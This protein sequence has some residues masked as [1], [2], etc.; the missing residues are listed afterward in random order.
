[1]LS[2]SS[3]LESIFKKLCFPDG[4]MWMVGQTVEMKLS[5]K[6]R[7]NV[8]AASSEQTIWVVPLSLCQL[9]VTGKKTAPHQ[10]L[11]T[12][13]PQDF[14]QPKRETK[15]QTKQMR[16][17]SQSVLNRMSYDIRKTERSMSKNQNE[18]QIKSNS[19]T[20]IKD[21]YFIYKLI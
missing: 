6:F 1:M 8:V 18:F 21:S 4:L 2:D 17:Y 10:I 14:A 19:N 15:R 7:H 9:C 16:D 11:G 20:T 13:L 5:F 12:L 3:A